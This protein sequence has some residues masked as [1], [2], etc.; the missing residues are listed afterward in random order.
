M[1]G[2]RQHFAGFMAERRTLH[3]VESQ[4]SRNERLLGRKVV[5]T[6]GYGSTPYGVGSW[7][8][9]DESAFRDAVFF[10]GQLWGA[11]DRFGCT[12][13]AGFGRER[14]FPKL[15]VE[16]DRFAAAEHWA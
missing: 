1:S 6:L 3:A 2:Y 14:F 13:P 16:A 4:P 11:G 5:C 12:P 9:W 7:E 10:S 8:T 15:G